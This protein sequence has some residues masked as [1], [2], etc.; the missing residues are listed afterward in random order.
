MPD[1]KIEFCKQ[2]DTFAIIANIIT[3]FKRFYFLY[4]FVIARFMYILC[5][6][7]FFENQ[8]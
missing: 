5:K 4:S 8:L 6:T 7:A 3:T 1:S 2:H